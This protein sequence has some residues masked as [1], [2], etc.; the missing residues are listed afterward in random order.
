MRGRRRR[1]CLDSTT[2][3]DTDT[4]TYTHANAHTNAYA[5][6]HANSDSERRADNSGASNDGLRSFAGSR[7]DGTGGREAG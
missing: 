6:T 4:D 1:H 7:V 2:A 5:H 3:S